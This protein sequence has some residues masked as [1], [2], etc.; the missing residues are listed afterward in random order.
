VVKTGQMAIGPGAKVRVVQP[1]A[2]ETRPSRGGTT[3]PA[4]AEAATRGVGP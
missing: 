3:A 2:D 1:L 4:A